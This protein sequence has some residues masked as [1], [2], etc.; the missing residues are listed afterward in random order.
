MSRMFPFVLHQSGIFCI[1]PIDRQG[2]YIL[3]GDFVYYISEIRK[4]V[5]NLFSLYVM[6]V[7]S[8][9]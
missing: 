8:D 2:F 3:C 5:S 6:M 7:L 9:E 1:V 4:W